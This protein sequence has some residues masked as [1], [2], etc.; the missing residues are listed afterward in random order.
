MTQLLT[1]QNSISPTENNTNVVIV[2]TENSSA[3]V[4]EDL[5]AI[6]SL[7]SIGVTDFS[8]QLSKVLQ[9]SLRDTATNRVTNLLRIPI[10]NKRVPYSENLL[11]Y[12]TSK[13]Q[14]LLGANKQLRL[15]VM[16]LGGT[17]A[18]SGLLSGSDLISVIGQASI[19][20][21]QTSSQVVQNFITA[22]YSVPSRDALQSI[23]L[24]ANWSVFDPS[25]SPKYYKDQIGRVHLT[26]FVKQNTQTAND[27][28]AVLPVG[29]RP[30]ENL[31][32]A[33]SSGS[34]LITVIVQA[35]G[36]LISFQQSGSFL[37]LNGISFLA[38]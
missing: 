16:N 5:Q 27:I 9:L 30:S 10:Y 8:N 31:D 13:S 17:I 24:N 32:F 33:V 36:N 15:S 28:V 11:S 21:T 12:L 23:A 6:V 29:Y 22:N 4:I 19:P 2:S 35:G 25:R 37:N 20:D 1:L 34:G 18:N 7:S 3:I 38:A 14:F 26:G